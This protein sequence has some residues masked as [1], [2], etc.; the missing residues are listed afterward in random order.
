LSPGTWRADDHV[1]RKPIVLKDGREIATL[2]QARALMLNLPFRNQNRVHW[3]YA[4]ELLLAAAEHG[5]NL[6]DANQQVAR[7]LAA[8]GLL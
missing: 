2:A 7:A 4:D 5:G 6:D 3:Q 1:R 8:D